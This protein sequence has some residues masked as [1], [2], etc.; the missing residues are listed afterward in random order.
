MGHQVARL[1]P[2]GSKRLRQQAPRALAV[3]LV[4]RGVARRYGALLLERRRRSGDVAPG[5]VAEDVVA[6]P[7]ATRGVVVPRVMV[8]RV[9]ARRVAVGRNQHGSLQHARRVGISPVVRRSPRETELPAPQISLHPKSAVN[10]HRHHR[11][12]LHRRHRQRRLHGSP[13]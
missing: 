8:P 13:S 10:A 4:A 6:R 1:Q 2:A 5:A 11:V 12:A 9:V 7:V 3:R